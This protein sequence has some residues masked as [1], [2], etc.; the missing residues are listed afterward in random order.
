MEKFVEQSLL[1]DFYGEL[2]TAHQKEVYEDY[3]LSNLSLSEIAEERNISRQSV[4]DLI[5]RCTKTLEEYEEKLNLIEKFNEIKLLVNEINTKTE[6]IAVK[7]ISS[8]ILE[9]L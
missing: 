3:V 9:K 6:E 7:E 4:H 5:K 1:Y 2:L 8:R